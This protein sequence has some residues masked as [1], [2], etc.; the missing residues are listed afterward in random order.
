MFDVLAYLLIA[1]AL[2][3]AGWGAVLVVRGR[4]LTNSLFYGLV[5]LEVGLLGQLVTGLVAL[6][7][8][9]R[10]VD[11]VT[12]VSYLLTAVLVLPVAVVWQAAEQT[13][14]GTAV[15]V[16]ACLVVPV[17]VVRLQQL[18]AGSGG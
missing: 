16:V 5:V 2:V 13:R 4:R 8:V 11:G 3:V 7:K 10:A 14:W 18:W 15:V 1:G 12:F 6:T 9:D 17:L